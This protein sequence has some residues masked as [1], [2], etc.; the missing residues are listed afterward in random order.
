MSA[1]AVVRSARWM[2]VVGI[3]AVVLLTLVLLAFQATAVFPASR[4]SAQTPTASLA[5]VR[6][7]LA[8]AMP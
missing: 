5:S 7:A 4:A 1:S 3:R 6:Q 8:A 2:R